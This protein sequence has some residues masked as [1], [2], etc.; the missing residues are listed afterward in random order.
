MVDEL[1][2]ASRVVFHGWVEE[3]QLAEIL[4]RHDVFL[5][6]SLDEP[7]GV[8]IVE[9]SACGLPV[10]VTAVGGIVEH[11][12]AG[13]TGL[14]VPEKDVPAMAS[15]MLQLA[16][17]PELRQRLGMAGRERAVNLYN[18]SLLTRRLEHVLLELAG[19]GDVSQTLRS[20]EQVHRNTRPYPI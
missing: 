14:Y 17:S 9:A 13:E 2:L 5:Q 11:V 1:G 4:P 12:I 16:R 7:F 10:V 20:N 8:S 3:R 15:A 18:S 19:C 6:H